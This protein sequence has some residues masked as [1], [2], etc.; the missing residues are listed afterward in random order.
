M[1]R[2]VASRSLGDAEGTTIAL[3]V[4][5]MRFTISVLIACVCC[6][7]EI[8]GGLNEPFVAIRGVF[9]EVNAPISQGSSGIA[10]TVFA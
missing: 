10:R 2:T 9:E 6:A 4:K 5:A 3:A 1:D 8:A 7:V